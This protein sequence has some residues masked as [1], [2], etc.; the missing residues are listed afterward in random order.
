MM[1]FLLQFF[2]NHHCI[3][4]KQILNWYS[5]GNEN[6]Y[7]GF[8]NARKLASSY[9]KSLPKTE[10]VVVTEPVVSIPIHQ[11]FMIDIKEE[12]RTFN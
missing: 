2:L 7:E 11:G 3:D 10:P 5:N 4:Q 8:D 1:S 12:P 9:I 6:G